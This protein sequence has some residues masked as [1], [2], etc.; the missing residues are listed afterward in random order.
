MKA[1][2]LLLTLGFSFKTFAYTQCVS[3]DDQRNKC[4]VEVDLADT[5]YV[6]SL[7]K[8]VE[9]QGQVIAQNEKKLKSEMIKLV[10][11]ARKNIVL[12]LLN[13][14]EMRE[15]IKEKIKKLEAN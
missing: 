15:I 11:D 6:N 3:Y 12:D 14:P 5:Q 4:L 2:I 1:L 10:A 9:K 13:D 8:E 7:A